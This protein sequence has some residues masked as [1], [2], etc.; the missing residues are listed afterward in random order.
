MD[1]AVRLSREELSPEPT[2]QG[3]G[4]KTAYKSKVFE[5]NIKAFVSIPF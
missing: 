3:Q 2:S 4:S 1:E 5:D